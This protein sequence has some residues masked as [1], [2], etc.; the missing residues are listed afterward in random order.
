MRLGC[1]RGVS[2]D[3][4]DWQHVMQYLSASSKARFMAS[5][6]SRFCL[7]SPRSMRITTTLPIFST[8][9]PVAIVSDLHTRMGAWTAVAQY[10]CATYSSRVA[11]SQLN[12]TTNKRVNTSCQYY[13]TSITTCVHDISCQYSNI[14]E[15]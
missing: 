2:G 12:W 15:Q 14:K 5:M 7:F 11:H 3:L 6:N 8:L 1:S 9:M 4:W 10:A 13:A